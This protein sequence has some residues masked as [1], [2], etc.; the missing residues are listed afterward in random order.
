MLL[1][2]QILFFGSELF[3]DDVFA[4]DFNSYEN[5]PKKKMRITYFLLQM[6]HVDV[7]PFGL[8][9]ID[10]KIFREYLASK[11]QC[12]KKNGR[13]IYHGNTLSKSTY[14]A[15][16]SALMHLYHV[17]DVEVNEKFA[18]QLSIFMGTIERIVR[19]CEYYYC[20]YFFL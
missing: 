18:K 12:C 9:C 5:I 7:C 2:M 3:V 17:F 20:V 13:I 14:D 6:N 16:Q 15:C 4:A 1:K 11:T 8:S 19:I 10:L